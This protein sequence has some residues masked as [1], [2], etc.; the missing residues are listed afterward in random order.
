METVIITYQADLGRAVRAANS[1]SLYGVGN[2]IDPI[3]IVINDGP[4]V[5]EQAQSL[6][7]NIKRAQVYHYTDISTW[8]H[9]RSGWW[10]QQWLKL[11]AYKLVSTEWY[12]PIDSD[13][14]LTRSI[15]HTELFSGR[16]AICNLHDRSMYQNNKKFI[17]YIDNACDYWKVDPD[18]IFQI[19]RE[20]PPNTLHRNSVSTMLSEMSP[21]V[22]GSIEKPSLE[23]YIYWIYLH[24]EN[25]TDLYQHQKNWFWFGNGFAQDNS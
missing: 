11:Q 9:A 20:T 4:A 24:K 25:C 3:H 15:K 10:S 2:L 17:E 16:R 14:Y 1:I 8:I 22:F 21:W 12:M 23:F 19:L 6:F 18:E 13:M 7:S 5:F